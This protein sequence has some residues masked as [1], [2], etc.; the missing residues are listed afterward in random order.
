[1]TKIEPI[2]DE[3]INVLTS[4]ISAE[5]NIRVH[6]IR[7]SFIFGRKLRPSV[8]I[9]DDIPSNHVTVSRQRNFP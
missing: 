2:W 6:C 9:D 8:G 4:H 3:Q 1:M 7:R 5:I